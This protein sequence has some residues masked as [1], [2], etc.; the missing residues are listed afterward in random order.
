M[1]SGWNWP[2]A[3][4]DHHCSAAV[5]AIAGHGRF[6]RSQRQSASPAKLGLSLPAA[7]AFPPRPG[8]AYRAPANAKERHSAVG[9]VP[10]RR[11]PVAAG[12]NC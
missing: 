10:A 11:R 7:V 4:I 3:G 6:S 9:L 12:A 1:S 2:G 5:M 8:E